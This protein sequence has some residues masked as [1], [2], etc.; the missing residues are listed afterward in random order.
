MGDLIFTVALVLIV[1]AYVLIAVMLL[2]NEVGPW[3]SAREKKRTIVRGTMRTGPTGP[4][5]SATRP[6]AGVER[7]TFHPNL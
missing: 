2:W 4:R 5:I 3:I 7:P 1:G 6:D